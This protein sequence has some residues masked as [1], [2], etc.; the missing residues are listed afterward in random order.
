MEKRKTK[1]N[2]KKN[3]QKLYYEPKN[4]RFAEKNPAYLRLKSIQ[5]EIKFI[6]R[7]SKTTEASTAELLGWKTEGNLQ[8]CGKFYF[9]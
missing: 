8:K 9:E 2:H 4:T 7:I 3:P 5:I 6:H 1:K